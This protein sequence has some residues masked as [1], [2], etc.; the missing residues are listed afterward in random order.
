MPHIHAGAFACKKTKALQNF[1]LLHQRGFI[2]IP[3]A[4]NDSFFE[5]VAGELTASD[6]GWYEIENHLPN[7]CKEDRKFFFK[8][9]FSLFSDAFVRE[10][11][12]EEGIWQEDAQARFTIRL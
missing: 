9:H 3:A 11:T 2:R 4:V 10:V 6:E 1:Q 8:S 12:N 7:G 5:E